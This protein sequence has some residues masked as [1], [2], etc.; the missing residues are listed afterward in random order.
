MHSD[1]ILVLESNI[2]L[3]PVI[4]DIGSDV[5]VSRFDLVLFKECGKVIRCLYKHVKMGSQNS[6][7]TQKEQE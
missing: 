3:L 2:E 7:E 6:D 5:K 1:I 4:D